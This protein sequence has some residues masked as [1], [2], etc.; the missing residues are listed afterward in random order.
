MYPRS[1]T[2]SS[3]PLRLANSVG[4][5]DNQYRN[6][7]RAAIEN[8]ST[9]ETVELKKGERYF[10]LCHPTLIAMKA[11]IIEKIGETTR[12]AGGFGSTGK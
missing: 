2:G 9:T 12:G 4:I 8:T 1:S 6:S 7:I 10:Q 5:I 3:T 11:N